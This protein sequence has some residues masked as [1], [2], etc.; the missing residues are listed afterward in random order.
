MENENNKDKKEEENK[1]IISSEQLKL[2]QQT[3]DDFSKSVIKNFTINEN[4]DI[5]QDIL[6]SLIPQKVFEAARNPENIII[7]QFDKGDG[8]F[9]VIVVEK[10]Y[11]IELTNE[12]DYNKYLEKR[13]KRKKLDAKGMLQ[14]PKSMDRLH[15]QFFEPANLSFSDRVL[16]ECT[17][18]ISKSNPTILQVVNYDGEKHQGIGQ[19][20]YKNILPNFA[21]QNECRFI[22][23]LNNSANSSFFI[24]MLGRYPIYCFKSEFRAELPCLVV[25][26]SVQILYEEDKKKILIDGYY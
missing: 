15:Q 7:K 17:L 26:T 11:P 2:A 4:K 25:D 3:R 12:D 8:N 13:E 24:E 18:N 20:F 6:L 19:D 10:D 16:M 21:R 1:I 5:S 14:K 22:I 9:S 23:G